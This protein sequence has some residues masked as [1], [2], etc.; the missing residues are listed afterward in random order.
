MSTADTF[1]E[2]DARHPFGLPQGAVRSFFALLISS[3]FWIVL[4]MPENYAFVPPLGHFVL[5]ALVLAAFVGRHHPERGE[6][7]ALPWLIII[8]AGTA[9][10]VAYVYMKDPTR[11]ETRLTPNSS[12]LPQLP[13]LMGVLFG[14]YAF[15]AL[16]GLVMGPKSN[17]FQSL[18]AWIGVVAGLLLI[19]ETVF[20]FAV[21]PGLANPPSPE[22][23]RI[24]E[25]ILIGPVAAYFGTR[26]V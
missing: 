16:L 25:A 9:A 8:L 13:L 22:A 19:A 15:G 1:Y 4:L 17:I 21:R 24:W 18:R 2:G 23:L 7:R 5:L 20:Q 14:G 12:E 3:Y 6:V 11:L 10:V 26:A